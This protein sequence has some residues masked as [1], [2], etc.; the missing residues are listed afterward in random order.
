[1]R[2]PTWL[3]HGLRLSVAGFM[4]FT[5]TIRLAQGSVISASP[6]L[7]VLNVPYVAATGAGCFPAVSVCIESGM[8]TMTSVVSSIIDASGQNI[9]TTAS[10]EGVLTNLSHIPIGTLALTGLIE[11][12]V[13]G[14]FSETAT[15]TWSTKLLE[16]ALAG[17]LFGFNLTLDLAPSPESSGVTSI[18]PLGGGGGGSDKFRIDSFFDI[19]V[20]L[21]L[22]T[23]IPLHTQRGP[24]HAHLVAAPEP[25]TLEL[26]GAGM[27]TLVSILL[28]RKP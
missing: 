11:Q 2:I 17:T 19:F 1:M 24:I 26:L 18:T 3:R 16:F 9:V 20:E 6:T 13:L 25:A 23:P 7:P 10:Y 8:L 27:A 4:V 15:G 14:R 5:A 21:T 22:D 28:R 12:Q